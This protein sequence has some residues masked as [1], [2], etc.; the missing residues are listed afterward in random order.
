MKVSSAG[1]IV[2]VHTLTGV[3]AAQAAGPPHRVPS[4]SASTSMR[5]DGVTVQSASRRISRNTC[6]ADVL[7][8]GASAFSPLFRS[9]IITPNFCF[10]EGVHSFSKKYCKTRKLPF[11]AEICRVATSHCCMM[12]LLSLFDRIIITVRVAF[13]SLS[14]S[15]F[16]DTIYIM[17]T[18]K[19][20][21]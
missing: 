5:D 15:T 19:V 4:Q 7:R 2:S 13:L 14:L 16:N 18:I 8:F 17:V 1:E 11:S 21:S 20:E 12:I 6:V 3:Y 10:P 9:W